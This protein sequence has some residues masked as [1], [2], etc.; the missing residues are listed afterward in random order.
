MKRKPILFL[1]GLLFLIACGQ[2]ASV[3]RS[4]SDFV[5]RLK[6]AQD[7]VKIF[8][9]QKELQARIITN[10]GKYVANNLTFKHWTF[11]VENI[12]DLGLDLKVPAPKDTTGYNVK[13]VMPVSPEVKDAASKLKVGDLIKVD[14][15][16]AM[17]TPEG[18]ISMND[19]FQ[20]DSAKF[21]KIAPTLIQ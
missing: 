3:P 7:T 16:I 6:R 17:K 13:F 4:Q 1:A 14:G 20:S 8:Q 18:K 2:K 12:S 10:M 5:M 15:E 19:Y 11:K 9:H 21:I